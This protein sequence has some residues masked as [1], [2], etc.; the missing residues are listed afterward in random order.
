M[1][2]ESK[3]VSLVIANIND[4]LR[5]MVPLIPRPHIL[6]V[7]S[8]VHSLSEVEL[9]K[10]FAMVREYSDFT[11]ENNPYLENDFGAIILNREKYFWK[12]DYDEND[13]RILTIMRAEEY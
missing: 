1:L 5:A 4:K 13:H 6:V 7:T 2:A 12:F 9:E 3:S 10:L 8:G 11:E